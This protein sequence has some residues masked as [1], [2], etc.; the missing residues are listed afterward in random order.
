MGKEQYSHMKKIISSI[1]AAF[2]LL[3]ITAFANIIPDHR[4]T[5][6]EGFATGTYSLSRAVTQYN[7]LFRQAGDQYGID[8]N[9]LAAVC[10]QESSG[11]NYSYREDGTEYPAWGIM[12]IEY[13]HEKSFAEFG[14]KREGV[15]W[16]LQDRLDPSKAIPYAAYLLSESLYK[17]N[18]DYAKMIQAYNFGD[19]VLSRIINAAGENWLNERKNAV[20][21]ADNWSYKSYGDAEYIEHVLRYYHNNIPYSGAK[22]EINGKLVKF[23]DQYPIIVNDSTLIP[24]RAVSETLGANV[25][26]NG[27]NRSAT[28]VKDGCEIVLSIDSDMVL[29]DGTEYQTIQAPQIINNRTMVPLRFIAEAYNIDVDWDGETRTVIISK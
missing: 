2:M 4:G 24:I 25:S 21:Y 11:I 17:Y 9:I 28:I 10:M 8:P 5:N 7:E 22:V 18:Y 15:A 26:W 6:L 14:L 3:E 23:E 27:N 19:I 16:T 12:Q 29:V 13:T 1:V 20:L